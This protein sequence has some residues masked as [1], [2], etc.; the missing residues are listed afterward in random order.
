[1]GAASVALLSNAGEKLFVGIDARGS[2]GLEHSEGPTHI[3]VVHMCRAYVSCRMQDSLSDA[4]GRSLTG[5]ASCSTWISVLS[6]LCSCLQERTEL[7]GSG[8]SEEVRQICTD[9]D[10]DNSYNY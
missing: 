9:N 3:Y 5:A 8:P 1:L 4:K 2:C 6:C 10:D 7:R